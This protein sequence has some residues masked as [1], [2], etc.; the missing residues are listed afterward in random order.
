[1]AALL[2]NKFNLRHMTVRLERDN[3]KRCEPE[4]FRRCKSCDRDRFEHPIKYRR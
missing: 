1:M 2:E 4:H 3:R